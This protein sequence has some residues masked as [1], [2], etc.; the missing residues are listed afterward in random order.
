MKRFG[1]TR[2][3]GIDLPYEKKGVMPKVWQFAAN[4]KKKEDN[5]FKATVSYGQGMTSTFM[6]VLKAYSIFNNEGISVTPKILS[7]IDV[8]GDKYRED[9]LKNDRVITKKTANEIKRL[10]V[11]TVDKGTGKA[12]KIEGLEIGGKTGTAQ[13]ARRGK[14][15]KKIYIIIFWFCK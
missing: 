6:Q 3:T 13:I 14:Y 4:D 7:Y 11:K 8:E 1:F 10:L 5:V 15:L 2:E 9:S 12:A